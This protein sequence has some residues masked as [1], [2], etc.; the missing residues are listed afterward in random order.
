MTLPN[1]HIRPLTG[2]DHTFLLDILY[3][4][5]Y[6]APGEPLPARD[7]LQQ[8][9]IRRYVA[10]WMQHK[11]DAGFVAEVEGKSI[12]AVWLRCW[13]GEDKGYGFVDV[14]IP[15]LSIAL[16]P[17]FRGKG[18]GTRLLKQCLRE[19]AQHHVAISLSVS[20]PNPAKN[21]YLRLGF[22]EIGKDGGSTTMLKQ[23]AGKASTDQEAW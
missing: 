11:G 16:L 6:V 7:I 19:A 23:L 5:I 8:P 17:G 20:D 10:D 13:T 1:V 3:H 22:V 2:D 4:A 14:T 15:E 9:D 12:G 18:I 21:L